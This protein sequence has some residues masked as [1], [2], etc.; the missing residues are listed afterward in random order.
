MKIAPGNEDNLEMER[1][2]KGYT[3][4][5]KERQVYIP[6]PQL[7]SSALKDSQTKLCKMCSN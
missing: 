7:E 1:L 3:I 5:I 4:T 2:G 6:P